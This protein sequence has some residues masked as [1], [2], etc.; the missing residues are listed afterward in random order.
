MTGLR[1][2]VMDTASLVSLVV[3]RLPRRGRRILQVLRCS[4]EL[5]D[6]SYRPLPRGA[7]PLDSKRDRENPERTSMR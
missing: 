7:S 5:V 6:R 3:V 4:A 2:L 1:H